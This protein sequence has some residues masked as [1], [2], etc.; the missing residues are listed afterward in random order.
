MRFP[1]GAW[2]LFAAAS[3]LPVTGAAVVAWKLR[4]GALTQAQADEDARVAAAAAAAEREIRDW[5]ADAKERAR[6]LAEP[7]GIRVRGADAIVLDADGKLK[8]GLSPPSE[9]PASVACESARAGLLGS[10][11]STFRDELLT[12]C[13][14]VR[15]T[16]GRFLWP[17]LALETEEGKR[18]LPR[19]LAGHASRLGP[20]EREVITARLGALEPTLRARSIAALE[21]RPNPNVV[22]AALIAQGVDSAEGPL[23]VRKGKCVAV[24]R[25]FEGEQSGCVFHAASILR[26]PPL[27]PSDL[28]LASGTGAAKVTV[29]PELLM[30]VE[31]RSAAAERDV[32]HHV[33]NRVFGIMLTGT[34]ATL[35]LAALM[36]A[37]FLHARR[38][39]ELRTDFVAAVSHELRTPLA[40]VQ[41]LAELLEGG[42]VEPSERAEVERTLAREARRLS[43][44]LIRMLRFGALSRGKLQP[45]RQRQPLAPIVREA[46]L[47]FAKAHPTCHVELELD[48][49][50]EADIDAALFGLVLD[51]LL[52]NAAKY[53]PDGGPY[54]VSVSRAQDVVRLSVADRGPGL[55]RAAKARVF[56]PFERA[57][58]RLVRA[59]EGT[60][61]GLALVRGIAEAHGGRTRV[62]SDLGRG[63]TFIVEVPWKPS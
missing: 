20:D 45:E 22:V 33:A 43:A 1:F 52:G 31:P 62:E 13:E 57:D 8:A 39:A 32:V 17:L 16:S 46:A 50:I 53:A 19:W 24:L 10:S 26:D 2:L 34:L 11:R 58:D 28:V 61:V 38:L 15:S 41:M 40:S 30:H 59:T 9:A 36:Y 56:L 63:A 18:E 55:D 54:R 44:T 48:V 3:A 23:R 7:E 14:D 27:L 60:G 6:K 21:T 51:N 47:R 42:V 25:T 49:A 35:L 12:H 5:I 37:R 29:A 4:A